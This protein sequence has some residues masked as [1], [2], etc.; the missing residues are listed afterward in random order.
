[1]KVRFKV[2]GG[3]DEFGDVDDEGEGLWGWFG[4]E[5]MKR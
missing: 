2:C 4:D 1:V 3:D 5:E